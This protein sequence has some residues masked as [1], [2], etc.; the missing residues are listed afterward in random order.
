MGMFS[1]KTSAPDP[2]SD[3][4]MDLPEEYSSGAEMAPVPPEGSSGENAPARKKTTAAA[5]MAVMSLALLSTSLTDDVRQTVRPVTEV[6]TQAGYTDTVSLISQNSRWSDEK[7]DVLYLSG[8]GGW[9]IQ[10]DEVFM[11]GAIS[12]TEDGYAAAD[13]AGRTVDLAPGTYTSRVT[14]SSVDIFGDAEK[15]TLTVSLGDSEETF[16]PDINVSLPALER[17][18]G[19]S[20][21]DMVMQTGLWKPSSRGPY[22]E[23]AMLSDGT[24][25]IQYGDSRLAVAWEMV[26][27]NMMELT[28]LSSGWSFSGEDVAE[29]GQTSLPCILFF[30][31]DGINLAVTS[32]TSDRGY[33]SFVP[34]DR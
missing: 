34:K 9:L 28:L 23:L 27:G 4:L 15:G 32:I 20:T 21:A 7:G 12:E 10:G 11:L 31:E 5:V 13:I 3:G 26:D 17:L 30:T 6:I 8:S 1:R 33:Q 19:I 29:G 22:S 24:G 14:L 25:Y 2:F 16:V 18:T